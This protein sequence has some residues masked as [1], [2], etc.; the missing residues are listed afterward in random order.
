MSLGYFKN[1]KATQFV[2][3]EEQ[4]NEM[5]LKTGDIGYKDAVLYFVSRMMI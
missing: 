3:N 1:L 5:I 2:R 4:G